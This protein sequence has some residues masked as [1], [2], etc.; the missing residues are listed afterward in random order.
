MPVSL[1]THGEFGGTELKF[2]QWPGVCH[3]QVLAKQV[4]LYFALLARTCYWIWAQSS[5]HSEPV[6]WHNGSTESRK[7]T[8][9]SAYSCRIYT[10]LFIFV[11]YLDLDLLV[12]YTS[13]VLEFIRAAYAP[14][15]LVTFR[16][17]MKGS[18]LWMAMQLTLTSLLRP[19][20]KIGILLSFLYWWAVYSFFLVPVF[21]NSFLGWTR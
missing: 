15:V 3:P 21:I 4:S 17:Y 8:P 5:A 18:R 10:M 16:S 2:L 14:I 19:I 7:L 20:F 11:P 6:K 9:T 13:S 1:P 12:T